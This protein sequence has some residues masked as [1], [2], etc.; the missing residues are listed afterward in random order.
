MLSRFIKRLRRKLTGVV[1]LKTTKSVRGTVLF[2]YITYPFLRPEGEAEMHTNYWQ[3]RLI[4]QMFLDKGYHVDVIDWTNKTFIPRKKYAYVFDIHDNLERFLPY[5]PKSC[6]KIVH[7]TTC[8]WRFNNAAEQRRLQDLEVRRGVKLKQRRA[9]LPARGQELADAVSMFGNEITAQTYPSSESF[10]RIPQ[11]TNVLFPWIERDYAQAA[12]HFV[13]VGGAGMV[14]K[15]LDLVLEVFKD[16]PGY[17][18]AIFGNVAGE[19]DFEDLYRRELYESPNIRCYGK[20]ALTS[21]A[22]QEV[23][24][25]SAALMYPSCSES[26]AGAVIECMHAGLIPLITK[27]CGVD[28]A[29]FGTILSSVK[30]EDLR[31]EVIKIAESSPNDLQTRARQAWEYANTHH[32]REQFAKGYQAFIDSIIPA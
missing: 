5:L 11:S 26:Q 18:L 8:E 2:S 29:P 6:V 30:V 24:K 12:K 31:Q 1:Y 7:L 13:W 14:H 27:E 4:A 22:F 21:D 3:C 10:V 28:V 23:A 15:G 25:H 20:I 32:T 19:A 16:L 17:Q 9:L